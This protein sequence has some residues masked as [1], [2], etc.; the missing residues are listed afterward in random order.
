MYLKIDN[1]TIFELRIQRTHQFEK[2]WDNKWC[3]VSL[4]IENEYFKYKTSNNELLLEA[5]IEYL[6]KEFNKLLNGKLK[7]KEEIEFIEPDLEFILYPFKTKE[8]VLVD[9]RIHLFQDGVLS[10]DFYNLCL[11]RKEI[12]QI[13]YYLNEILPTVEIK[14][15]DKKYNANE[16]YCIVSVKYSDYDGEKTYAYIITNKDEKV[17]VGDEV[18]V[19]RAGKKVLAQIVDVGYYNEANAPYPINRTKKVIKVIKTPEDFRKYQLGKNN[20]FRCPCCGYYTLDE[21]DAYEICP[22]CY[23]EDDPIQRDA[24]DYE[25]SS[26]IPSL[27]I[28]K[29][30]YKKFYAVE[31]RFRKNVRCPELTETIYYEDYDN[32]DDICK[33]LYTGTKEEIIYIIKELKIEYS[34]NKNIPEF[35]INIEKIGV[36]VKGKGKVNPK[37]KCI[38]YFGY[39]FSYKNLIKKC[40]KCNNELVDILY[41]VPFGEAFEKA[42]NQELYLGGC[43]KFIGLEQPIY[44]CYNC[45]RSYYKNL[46][47][48]EEIENEDKHLN[49]DDIPDF[50]NK[51]KDEI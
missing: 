29:E 18:L 49:N 17:S 34:F 31:E 20:K 13:V 46:V 15:I 21:V 48:Y 33:V 1:Y 6:I 27:K 44:H 36:V 3:E 43:C 42:E 11:D 12:K 30:N 8:D 24:P 10:A 25:G 28:A 7:E 22:V 14:D 45:N 26:N 35:S 9:F 4:K 51:N 37:Y 50:L 5:D 23:W 41:G 2:E 39:K 16:H 47:D 40:P 38:K 32:V 19:D